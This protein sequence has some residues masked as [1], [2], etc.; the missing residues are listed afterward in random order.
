MHCK[1]PLEIPR[2]ALSV[3]A[4]QRCEDLCS[5]EYSPGFFWPGSLSVVSGS[6]RTSSAEVLQELQLCLYIRTVTTSKVKGWPR[7][8][9]WR[10]KHKRYSHFLG[11]EHQL[12][13]SS[14]LCCWGHCC[15]LVLRGQSHAV[16]AAPSPSHAQGWCPPC[17]GDG[18]MAKALLPCPY[19]Q[20]GQSPPEKALYKL[21]K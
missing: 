18:Q 3:E 12:M 14:G 16:S 13:R 15:P 10:G 11:A 19:G 5:L 20:K 21:A 7:G 4:A 9:R 1:A 17:P 2:Q 6:L 8:S